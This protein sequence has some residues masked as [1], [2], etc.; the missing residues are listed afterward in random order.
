MASTPSRNHWWCL[1]RL[2]MCMNRPP[3]MD[4]TSILGI[5]LL[6]LFI[7]LLRIFLFIF[8]RT[9]ICLHYVIHGL[10]IKHINNLFVSQV[11]KVMSPL[12]LFTWMCGD[13]L[14]ILGLM[15]HDITLFLLIIIQNIY[16][17]IQWPL[18]PM[19]LQIFRISKNLLKPTFKNQSKHYI[20]TMEV[21]LLL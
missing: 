3:L 5:L 7:I 6:K 11:S 16:G 10:L 4:D 21:S 15:D 18:N 19:F 17:F 1:K 8:P 2:L 12:N 9:K 14:V 20:L 13:L